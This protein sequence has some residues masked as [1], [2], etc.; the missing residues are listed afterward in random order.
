MQEYPISNEETHFVC[1]M[2]PAEAVFRW[3]RRYGEGEIVGESGGEGGEG[4]EGQLIE[5]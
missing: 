5:A 2:D 3:V 1:I 4:S